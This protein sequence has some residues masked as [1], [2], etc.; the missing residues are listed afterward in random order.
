MS[1]FA[2]AFETGVTAGPSTSFAASQS[3]KNKNKRKRPSH[4]GANAASSDDQLRAAQK[5]LEKLMKSIDSSDVGR[6]E[7]EK[8]GRES[9][10]LQSKKQKAKEKGATPERKGV[11]NAQSPLSKKQ[12]KG[13]EG[14]KGKAEGR[15]TKSEEIST[16][17]SKKEKEKKKKV[18]EIPLPPSPAVK[19]EDT[20]GLTS[21]QKGMKAKLEGAR[22]R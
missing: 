7:I 11:T 4:G 1:L 5:N 20:A 15:P 16:P 3:G 19:E 13:G 6:K 18:V 8:V 9:M 2:S 17:Q 22:F 10:G 21:M 14:V 12:K